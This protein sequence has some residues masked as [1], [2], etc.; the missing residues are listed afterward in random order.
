VKEK[1][2]KLEASKS[3]IMVGAI[4]DT[5]K[6]YY[7]KQFSGWNTVSNADVLN[8]IR[9]LRQKAIDKE[10]QANERRLGEK[11]I[12]VFDFLEARGDPDKERYSKAIYKPYLLK[13]VKRGGNMQKYRLPEMIKANYVTPE[14]AKK[15]I[16]AKYRGG[17][18][19]IKSE[20]EINKL[21]EVAQNVINNMED[22][23]NALQ[24]I[25]ADKAGDFSKKLYNIASNVTSTAYQNILN[26]NNDVE[27][28]LGEVKMKVE[29]KI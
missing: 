5:Y 8:M 17:D 18:F 27:D 6:V 13:F 2:I 3:Q 4:H 19:N 21:Y 1:K 10:T 15:M 26:E 11:E 29:G 20:D 7:K 24:T 25:S 23:E 14:D 12:A 9:L 16:D 28:E 22:P